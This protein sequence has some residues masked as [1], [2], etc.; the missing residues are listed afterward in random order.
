VQ[1]QVYHLLHLG[2]AAGQLEIATGAMHYP[3]LVMLHGVHLPLVQVNA[4]RCDDLGVQNVLL[5]EPGHDWHIVL[6]S[7]RLHFEGSL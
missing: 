1:S 5:L 4:V 7:T 3:H 2:H 6:G